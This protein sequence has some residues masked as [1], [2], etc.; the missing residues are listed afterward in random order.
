MKRSQKGI[1]CLET[2]EWFNTLK[3]KNS[4]E[5]LLQLLHDSPLAVQYIHRDIATEVELRYY[6]RKWTQSKHKD[7]PILYLAFHGSPGCI[8][9]AT[10]NGRSATFSTDDLF[11]LL[12]DKCHKRVIH[13]GACSV[14]KIH[15]HQVNRYLRDSCAVAISGYAHDV[16]WVTSS[17]FEMLYLAELQDN[18]FTKPGIRAVRNRVNKIASSLSKTLNFK[19]RIRK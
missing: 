2:G 3:K 5:P 7:Y 9:L 14:L 1:Y 8:H 16:G 4:V 17:I 12:R 6:L 10:E 11:E 18:Q 15:G 13:F 19:I